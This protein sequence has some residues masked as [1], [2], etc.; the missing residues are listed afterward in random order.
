MKEE[1]PKTCLASA[2]VSTNRQMSGESMDGQINAIKKYAEREN[3]SILPDG[4]VAFEVFSGAKLRPVYENHIR[5]IKN[6]PG[7]VG[8]YVIRYINRFTRSGP[9]EYERMKKELSDLGVELVDTYG[10]IQPQRTM[11]ELE[12]LGFKYN[13]AI[14][15]PSETTEMLMALQGREERKQI[16]KR[17]IPKQIEY[18]Q[19]GYHIGNYD[20]GYKQEKIFD[21]GKIRFIQVPDG[22]R[23]LMIKKIFELRAENKLSD[24]EIVDYLNSEMGYLSQ[25]KN[26]WN[27][28]RTRIIGQRGVVKLSVKQMQRIIQRTTY[29]GVICEK[30]TYNKPI[31]AKYPGLVDIDTFNRAN[32]GK[33]FLSVS[34]EQIQLIQNYKIKAR[35]YKRLRNNPE[36]PFKIIKCPICNNSLKGSSSTGKSG[37]RFPAYHCSREHQRFSVSKDVMHNLIEDTLS[38]IRYSNEYI[39][40]LEKV[41]LKKFEKRLNEEKQEILNNKEKLKDLKIEQEKLVTSYINTNNEAVKE[42]LDEKISCTSKAILDTGN[43]VKFGTKMKKEDIKELI[44]Y[45]VKIVEHPQKTLIDKDNPLRQAKLLDLVFDGYPTYKEL[46]SGTPRLSI[47]FNAKIEKSTT[48]SSTLSQLGSVYGQDKEIIVK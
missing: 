12:N 29:A 34:G 2:R 9:V 42:V 21:E 25:R 26:K 45:L 8:Y 16:L 13:W 36:F 11:P 7:K 6:N 38:N 15:S 35:E 24:N 28:E 4:E 17:T 43:K 44:Q 47:F 1:R 5:Y 14:E 3:L 31:K 40:L 33:V 41:I 32:R 18:T 20:D 22:S 10:V 48:Q 39:R 27:K 37:K 23:S 30:W 19:K 46:N